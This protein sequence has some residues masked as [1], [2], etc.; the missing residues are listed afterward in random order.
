MKTKIRLPLLPIGFGLITVC[1]LIGSVSGSIAWWAFSTRV[2]V[3]YQGTSVASSEQLQIGL[4][5]DID[6]SGFGLTQVGDYYFADPGAGLPS[7]TIDHFLTEQ[8]LYASDKLEPVTSNNYKDGDTFSLKASLLAGHAHNY[9]SAP[10]TKYVK[11]PFAFRIVRYNASNVLDYAKGENIWLSDTMVEASTINDGNVYKAI[12]IYTEGKMN[13]GTSLVDQKLLINPS[14]EE[15]GK[16]QTAVA[17]LLNLSGG[18]TFYDYDVIG[19]EKY[20]IIYGES[21]Y[22]DDELFALE[23]TQQD[24]DNDSGWED[25]NNTG[26]STASPFGGTTFLAKYAKGVYRPLNQAAI[27]PLYAEYDTLAS[28]RPTDDN[29]VL[30]EGKPLCATD[31]TDGIAELDMTIWLEGWDHNVI[32]QENEHS[33][34][35][36]LQF[37]IS[38]L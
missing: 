21:E 11:I 29:G 38:I 16:G 36:G 35:L 5:T 34:N 26:V 2:T 31:L 4:K 6:M 19:G 32:D 8:G 12:R 1:G 14:S 13:N 25:F 28:V 33:F 7:G 15:T 24:P 22:T 10:T 37:Q 18:N 23:T 17:G 30:S 20:A 27:K 3:A 9:A